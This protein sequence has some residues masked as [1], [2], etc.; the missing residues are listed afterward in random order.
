MNSGHPMTQMRQTKSIMMRLF[1]LLTT[2]AVNLPALVL[3]EHP[4]VVILFTDDH[5]TLDANCYGSTDL[6]TPN[7]DRLAEES[8]RFTQAYAHKVCCPSRAALL[9]GRH[10]QRTRISDWA[11]GNRY[12]N[13]R[14]SANLKP[15]EV[16]IVEV[17]KAA[18]YRSALFGKWHLGAKVGH[19]PLD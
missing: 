5:G 1:I 7:I 2:C 12:G 3:A 8:V 14:A 9:T 13:S 11:R 19:G 18:G 6:M 4:N 15:E 16:T 10:P 17:L